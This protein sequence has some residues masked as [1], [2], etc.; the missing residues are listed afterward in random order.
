MRKPPYF[1]GGRLGAEPELNILGNEFL[2]KFYFLE[3]KHDNLFIAIEQI[4][5]SKTLSRS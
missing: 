2:R 5:C 1:L 3:K 4:N